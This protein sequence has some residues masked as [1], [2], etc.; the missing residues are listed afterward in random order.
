VKTH[1]IARSIDLRERRLWDAMREV[2]A[3]DPRIMIMDEHLSGE[4]YRQLVASADLLASLHRSEGL[5]YNLLEAMALGIPCLATDYSGSRDF[6]RADTAFLVD[7]KLVPILPGQYP[8]TRGEQLWAEPDHA[9]AVAALRSAEA[10]PARRRRIAAAGRDLATREFG[11]EAFAAR[12][13]AALGPLIG[14]PTIKRDGQRIAKVRV[15][16][17]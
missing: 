7:C 3:A 4:S 2:A 9:G 16:L 12:L 5:G 15:Q 6:C 8:F 14:N 10:D 11:M 1:S 13:L 17:T